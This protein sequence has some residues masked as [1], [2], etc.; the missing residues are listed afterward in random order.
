MQEKSGA[1]M[2]T[3]HTGETAADGQ[4]TYVLL[5]AMK[6]WQSVVVFDDGSYCLEWVP[7]QLR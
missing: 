1:K 6:P 2:A 3:A 5:P 7:A 4:E